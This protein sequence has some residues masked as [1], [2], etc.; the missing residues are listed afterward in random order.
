MIN[1]AAGNPL[2]MT[3]NDQTYNYHRAVIEVLYMA[4]NT[5]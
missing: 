1:D 2:T 3:K 4:P 5:Q